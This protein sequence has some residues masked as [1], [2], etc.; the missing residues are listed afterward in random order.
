LPPEPSTNSGL[1]FLGQ[2][3]LRSADIEAR[4]LTLAP[5][6][7]AIE[8][9]P[10][11]PQSGLNY[12]TRPAHWHPP[13]SAQVSYYRF[14]PTVASIAGFSERRRPLKATGSSNCWRYALEGSI[15]SEPQGRC[16]RDVAV[17]P[18]SAATVNIVN[19]VNIEKGDSVGT[20]LRSK[21][22]DTVMRPDFP[23]LAFESCSGLRSLRS[24]CS[25]LRP[26]RIRCLATA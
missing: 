25:L 5:T 15:R 24:L 6:S 21:A 1:S 2:R 19:M 26:G 18:P 4:S 14:F 20:I 11:F 17:G 23:R 22:V 13:V 16:W 10:R 7:G 8:K 3:N 9:R 12:R